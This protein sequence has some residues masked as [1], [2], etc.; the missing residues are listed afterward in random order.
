MYTP[1]AQK[2]HRTVHLDH[3]VEG[4]VQVPGSECPCG[5]LALS[6]RRNRYQEPDNPAEAVPANPTS[7]RR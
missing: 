7:L 5:H 3:L 1:I 6:L 2:G 4:V